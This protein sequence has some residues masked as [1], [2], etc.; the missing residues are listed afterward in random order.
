M[1]RVNARRGRQRAQW[2]S[3]IGSLVLS[4]WI[5]CPAFAGYAI[6]EM[7]AWGAWVDVLDR[8]PVDIAHPEWG[9]A[10]YGVADDALGPALGDTLTVVSLGDG[11]SITLEFETAIPDGP[12]DDFAVFE[13][14]FYDNSSGDLFAELAF[15]EVSSNGIDFARLET[16]TLNT[17]PVGTGGTLNPGLYFGFAGLDE[18]GQGTGFDLSEL[19]G[20]PL[21]T[22][23]LLDLQAIHFVRLVD[24]VGDGS[25]FDDF[26][27]PIYDPYPTPFASGGFDLD[28]VGVIHAPEPG[29]SLLLTG[30]LLV[31]ALLGRRS[32]LRDR[33]LNSPPRES[34]A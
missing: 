9:N 16:E 19:L 20:H 32:G 30:G 27:Q 21:E 7:V 14:A 17:S 25:T 13:N 8:G 22:S 2:R 11:G 28:G 26:G 10:S 24:V 18:A 1:S 5:A 31:M 6:H 12:G 34:A 15:V 23:G 3:L 4:S 29:Q 33:R